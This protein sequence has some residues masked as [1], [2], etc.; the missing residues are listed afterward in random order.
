MM[1]DPDQYESIAQQYTKMQTYREH[2]K[3][4]ID[5][6]SKQLTTLKTDYDDALKAR[7]LIQDTAQEIQNTVQHQIENLVSTALEA[8]FPDP[9]TFKLTFVQKRNKTECE[10]WLCKNDEMI[11][12]T[13]N[14]GGGVLDILSIACRISFWT[15]NKTFPLLIMDEPAK[16]VSRKYQPLVAELFKMLSEKLEMQMII[17]SHIDEIIE[18]ADEVLELK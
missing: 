10:I 9:Y 1:F 4:N 7:V 11:K 17:A 13:D 6:N 16:F 5:K 2:L 15:F 8:V 18:V 3:L 12:P 14:V